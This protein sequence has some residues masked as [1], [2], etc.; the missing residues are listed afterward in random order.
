MQTQNIC[1]QPRSNTQSQ[2]LSC[3]MKSLLSDASKAIVPDSLIQTGIEI[4]NRDQNMALRLRKESNGYE[5]SFIQTGNET[6]P[7]KVDSRLGDFGILCSNLPH[8]RIVLNSGRGGKPG[9]YAYA[10]LNRAQLDALL[11]P[12]HTV[13]YLPKPV[14]KPVLRDVAINLALA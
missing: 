3:V 9:E 10:N 7:M 5:L 8:S 12:G 4:T 6:A 2:S 13:G 11:K 1:L 14:S